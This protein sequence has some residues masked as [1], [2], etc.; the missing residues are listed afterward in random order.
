MASQR[1]PYSSECQGLPSTQGECP[2]KSSARDCSFSDQE[3]GKRKTLTWC[4][5]RPKGETRESWDGK[6]PSVCLAVQTA[7]VSKRANLSFN[8]LS[9]AS[10][11]TH[12]HSWRTGWSLTEQAGGVLSSALKI[13]GLRDQEK[14]VIPKI[15]PLGK[16]FDPMWIGRRGTELEDA[17]STTHG[18]SAFAQEFHRDFST[19]YY[20]PRQVLLG[21]V[22]LLNP[23]TLSPSPLAL[24]P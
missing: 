8:N 19:A 3:G 4:E 7:L 16:I 2:M 18:P 9:R 21:L 15:R 20:Y 6:S 17:G 13:H 12:P 10:A 22:H 24:L 5:G 11:S 1:G 23:L 14:G